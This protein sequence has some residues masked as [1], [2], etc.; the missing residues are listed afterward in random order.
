MLKFL[1]RQA[2]SALDLMY[3]HVTVYVTF[4]DCIIYLPAPKECYYQCLPCSKI[5]RLRPS[6]RASHQFPFTK[7][8]QDDDL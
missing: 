2:T 8:M 1:M 6:P 3:F 4:C 5:S 7:L